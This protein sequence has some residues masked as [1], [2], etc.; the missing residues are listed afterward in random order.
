MNS[1][2]YDSNYQ[3]TFTNSL[4]RKYTY[5]YTVIDGVKR[6]S[7][8]NG[9]A[10]SLCPKID[11]IYQYNDKGLLVVK[12]DGKGTKTTYEYN[13]KGQETSRTLA[14]GTSEAITIKTTWDDRFFNKPKTEAYPNKTLSYTY[15]NDGNLTSVKTTTS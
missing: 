14:A 10:S 6:I 2:T 9:I 8:I 13:D 4:G 3:T 15:D 1:G 5:S 11:S 7:A 12:T